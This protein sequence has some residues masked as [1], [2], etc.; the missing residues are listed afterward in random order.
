MNDNAIN[1]LYA[2]KS[3]IR[4]HKPRWGSSMDIETID[5]CIDL[6]EAL[7]YNGPNL[8]KLIIEVNVILK[9]RD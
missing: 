7:D 6:F 4:E 1:T 9:G 8:E 5:A 3:Y 2:L